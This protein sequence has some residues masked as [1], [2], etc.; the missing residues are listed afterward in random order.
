MNLS[1]NV[2]TSSNRRWKPKWMLRNLKMIIYLTNMK[3][4]YLYLPF[5]NV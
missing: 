4:P 5:K 2:P 3:L 1:I